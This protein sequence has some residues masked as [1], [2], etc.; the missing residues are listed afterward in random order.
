[1][2]TR[3]E[4]TIDTFGEFTCKNTTTQGHETLVWFNHMILLNLDGTIETMFL[5]RDKWYSSKKS[6]WIVRHK[7][8]DSYR[9]SALL[10]RKYEMYLADQSILE[11]IHG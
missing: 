10:Q 1:M 6:I 4:D 7:S 3:R 5:K 2:K 9:A 11:V 8:K